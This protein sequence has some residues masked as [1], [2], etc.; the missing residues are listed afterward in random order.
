MHRGPVRDFDHG[1]FG[2]VTEQPGQRA[3]VVRVE[4]LN[5]HERHPGVVG[6]SIQQLA[7]RLEA[8]GRSSY[9][10]HDAGR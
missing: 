7:K 1:Q 4:M 10:D 2:P 8:S 6:E 3:A 9:S 5:Q